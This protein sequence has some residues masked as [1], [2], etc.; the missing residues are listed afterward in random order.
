MLLDSLFANSG[1]VIGK[2]DR[3][4]VVLLDC[5]P[6]Y[7]ADDDYRL[8]HHAGYHPK[9]LEG[10]LLSPLWSRFWQDAHGKITAALRRRGV[11]K[12]L[13][14]CY[15]KK[16]RHRSV[17]VRAQLHHCLEGVDLEFLASKDLCSGRLWRYLCD[18]AHA[19]C[20]DCHPCGGP[21]GELA[22]IVRATALEQWLVFENSLW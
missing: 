19:R 2:Y 5:R 3:S 6:L 9:T 20:S 12:L 7:N 1:D 22:D 21:L 8:T 18:G 10:L 16:G 4:E 14:V 11:S 13:V 15:C 17:G